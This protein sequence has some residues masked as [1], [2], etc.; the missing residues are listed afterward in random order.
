MWLPKFRGILYNT[1]NKPQQ[2]ICIINDTKQKM[3]LSLRKIWVYCCT[4]PLIYATLVS[5][6]FQH[7]FFV[8]LIPFEKH[9]LLISTKQASGYVLNTNL[10]L[11]H[12]PQYCYSMYSFFHF[13]FFL[14]CNKKTFFYLYFFL[15]L[16]RSTR[17]LVPGL[18]ND[19]MTWQIGYSIRKF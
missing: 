5:V 19:F 12:M 17:K 9:C 6:H 10:H 11:C 13:L 3:K 4:E 1:A 15:P 14:H 2:F 18:T 7:S 8:L 16:L